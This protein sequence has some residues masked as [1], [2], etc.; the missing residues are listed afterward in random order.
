MDGNIITTIIYGEIIMFCLNNQ[1]KPFNYKLFIFFCFEQILCL[2]NTI[3]PMYFQNS[4]IV[5][6]KYIL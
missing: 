4:I 2:L 5:V 6:I 1:F 3:L